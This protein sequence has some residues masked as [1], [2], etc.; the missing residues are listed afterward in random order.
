MPTFQPSPNRSSSFGLSLLFGFGVALLIMLLVPLTQLIPPQR[1]SVNVI[2]VA[3]VAAPPP[4]P[5]IEDSPP[6]PD[7]EEA[8]PPPELEVPPP[9]PTLEQLEIA[10]N[11]G[12]GDLSVASGLGFAVDFS[13]ESVAQ[14]EQLFGFGELDEVPHLVREG[15][16]RYPP[17]SPR[18]RGEAYVKLLIY[19]ESDGRISVQ[20]VIDYSHQE[21]LE[22]A[23][24]MAEG[25]RFSPPMRNGLAVRS[26]YEW[27]IRIPLK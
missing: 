13:T 4:P 22:A 10:L 16:F 2:E 21:F 15:R 3:E 1:E 23:K 24:R 11:P 17:N 6:P 20:K 19:V 26:Q 27:P 7:L 9:M 25:S 8:P 18:G 5:R 14:L 12:T